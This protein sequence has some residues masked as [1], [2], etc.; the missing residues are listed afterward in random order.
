MS[1]REERE[2]YVGLYAISNP[3]LSYRIC[4]NQVIVSKHSI[5][6]AI[7]IEVSEL[8]FFST[9]YRNLKAYSSPTSFSETAPYD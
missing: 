7:S 3:F 1:A 8:P 9:L 4:L 5:L 2:G 6:G